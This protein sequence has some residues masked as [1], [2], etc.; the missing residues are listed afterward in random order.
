[1]SHLLRQV[2]NQ[3]L[4]IF[5]LS[6]TA[7]HNQ[8]CLLR[9]Q[10]SQE[11]NKSRQVQYTRFST[12]QN[13]SIIRTR[14]VELTESVLERMKLR[15]GCLERSR[16]DLHLT[17]TGK[18]KTASKFT[19]QRIEEVLGNSQFVSCKIMKPKNRSLLSPVAAALSTC[20]FW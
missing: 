2:N 18:G 13:A 4:S 15:D 11:K 9:L 7:V 20:Q 10:H 8:S 14:I 1:M 12:F 17:S 19:F 5:S 16:T 6:L 3:V